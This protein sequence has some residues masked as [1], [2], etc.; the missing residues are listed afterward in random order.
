MVVT[1]NTNIPTLTAKKTIDAIKKFYPFSGYSKKFN[2][3]GINNIN[4]YNDIN[5][6]E[7][8]YLFYKGFNSTAISLI[9]SSCNISNYKD[10]AIIISQDKPVYCNTYFGCHIL[11][12]LDGI[13]ISLIEIHPVAIPANYAHELMHAGRAIGEDSG[14]NPQMYI[15]ESINN[16]INWILRK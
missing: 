3:Y 7:D 13:P 8:G 12:S 6:Y 1:N 4:V 5:V 15:N 2:I 9:F 14:Y 10:D 16:V 11:E